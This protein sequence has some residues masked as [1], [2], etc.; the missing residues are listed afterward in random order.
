VAGFLLAIN[1]PSKDAGAD[2]VHISVW[3]RQAELCNEYLGKG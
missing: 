2:F 1:R 3:D